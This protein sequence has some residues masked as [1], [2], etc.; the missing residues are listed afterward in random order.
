MATGDYLRCLGTAV[1]KSN[2][3]EA[4]DQPDEVCPPANILIV[5][6]EEHL[7]FS[8]YLTLRKAGHQ[9]SAAANGREAL[10]I[11]HN[12]F[13]GPA[14][15][16]LMVLD[17]RMPQVD[18]LTLLKILQAEHLHLPVIGITGSMEFAVIE[19]MLAHGCSAVLRKPFESDELL[20]HID[21]ALRESRA[22]NASSEGFA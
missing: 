3:M 7:R 8:V 10:A 18:G 12:Q 14:P 21:N 4:T 20:R 2:G 11:L 15:I 6:D 1:A 22:R 19:Q 17:L 9:V 5:D 16:E 13:L